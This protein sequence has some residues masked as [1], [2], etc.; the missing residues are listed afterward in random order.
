M[1]INKCFNCGSAT[2]T[3]K[4]TGLEKLSHNRIDV[5]INKHCHQYKDIS[6]LVPE[7]QPVGGQEK[8]SPIHDEGDSGDVVGR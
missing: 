2:V 3:Y 7:W 8:T 5:C 4:R 1:K 6:K